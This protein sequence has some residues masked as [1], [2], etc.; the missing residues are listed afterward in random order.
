MTKIKNTDNT[1]HW[2]DWSNWIVGGTQM[3]VTLEKFGS[4][5]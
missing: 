3:V 1:K 2:K 4:F 5:L